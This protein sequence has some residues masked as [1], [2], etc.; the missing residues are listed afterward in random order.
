[1]RLPQ[2]LVDIIVDNIHDDIPSLGSCSLAARTFVNS[3]RAHLFKKIQINPPGDPPLSSCEKFYQLLSSSPHIAPLVE[4]LCIVTLSAVDLGT[5]IIGDLDEEQMQQHQVSW[6][7]GDTTLSLV[8]PLLNL[9]RISLIETGEID[10]DGL[11]YSMDWGKMEQPLKSALTSVFSSPRLEAVHLRGIVIESP[12]QLL[13]SLSEATSLKEMSISRLYYEFPWQDLGELW[14]E[15]PLWRP[16]LQ[17]LLLN[18]SASTLLFHYLV[19]PQISLAHIRTLTLMA[20]V[21]QMK[22]IIP[23]AKSVERLRLFLCDGVWRRE[24]LG[25]NLRSLHLFQCY[26]SILGMLGAV[27]KTCPPDTRLEHIKLEGHGQSKQ[28][29]SPAEF[30]T[31]D[32]TV[33][34]PLKTVELCSLKPNWGSSD[35]FAQWKAA[36]QAALPSLMQQGTLR[37]T[38]STTMMADDWNVGSDVNRGWE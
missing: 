33:N 16:R 2:E 17:T 38:E 27:L 20:D 25:T 24:Y 18:T 19:H 29:P 34:L 8:L 6:I 4:D 37:V 28:L 30:A 9:K 31:I 22:M 14:P 23:A 21:T 32:A 3:A 15:S 12:V 11:R 10:W 5:P 26:T 1:M 7:T 36:V 35:T 13:S